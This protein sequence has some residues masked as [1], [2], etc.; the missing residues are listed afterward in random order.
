MGLFKVSTTVFDLCVWGGGGVSQK[1]HKILHSGQSMSRPRFK[2]RTSLMFVANT[3]E[4]TR[5]VS[6][7]CNAVTTRATVH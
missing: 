2:P 3:T 6:M 5:L 7:R 1:N 4:L